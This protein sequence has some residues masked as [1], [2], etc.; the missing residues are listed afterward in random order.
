MTYAPGENVDMVLRQHLNS[1]QNSNISTSI[2]KFR[3]FNYPD[4]GQIRFHY[5]HANDPK[6]FEKMTHGIHTEKNY[7]I[8]LIK[9]LN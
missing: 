9:I 5:G 1:A 8:Y 7:V 6:H 2:N 4:V 3:D